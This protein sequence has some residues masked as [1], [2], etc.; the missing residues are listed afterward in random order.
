MGPKYLHV[1][2]KTKV[3][4]T[5]CCLNLVLNNLKDL[6][7]STFMEMIDGRLQVP[8]SFLIWEITIKKKGMGELNM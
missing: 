1:D 2:T 3:I 6:F 7:Q 8:F 5:F 4:F